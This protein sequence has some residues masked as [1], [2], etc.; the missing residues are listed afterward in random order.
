MS[1]AWGSLVLCLALG[2]AL[3]GPSRGAYRIAVASEPSPSSHQILVL[4]RLPPAH[5]RPSSGYGGAGGYG[6]GE[7][8]GARRRIAGALARENG[9]TLLD[10]WPMPVVGLDCFIMTTPAGRSPAEV[11][12]RLTRDP[13]V[14]WSQPMGLFHAQ[15]IARAGGAPGLPSGRL[16]PVQPAA[17]EWRLIDLHQMAT[18]RGVRVAV[19]DSMI[20]R[21]HPD[22]L[23]QAPVSQDF[24][25]DHPAGPE[26]HGTGVAGI[27][28]AKGVGIVGV[29]PRARLMALRACWQSGSGRGGASIT[30]C[31]TL[32][33]AKALSFAVEHN[34]QV[35]NLSLSGP[36]DPLLGRLLDVAIAR[37]VAVVGAFDRTLPGGGF[38]AS[39]AGVVAVAAESMDAP[40][41][42]IY[43]AP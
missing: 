3:I 31:D 28:A 7:G 2:S 16:F 24:V 22:L 30:T 12:A 38:P 32:S 41:A 14:A 23:G 8:R 20:E 15:S 11:A 26:R 43:S 1:R 4:L 10:D 13:R 36:P 39:H 33:L 6:D 9:L 40:L 5:L 42:G 17:R 19:I 35:I 25:P 27:I 37:G 21:S 34:A 29:A 18:G